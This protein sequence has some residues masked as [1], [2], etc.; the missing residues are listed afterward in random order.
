M[1]TPD[2]GTQDDEADIRKTL[3][4]TGT[5]TGGDRAE[6]GWRPI[7]V[8]ELELRL[9]EALELMMR[10]PSRWILI[11]ETASEHYVQFLANEDGVLFAECVSNEFLKGEARLSEEA[12]EL[13]PVLGWQWPAPPNQPNWV[14]VEFD[15]EAA[16][17]VAVLALHTLRR[18]FGCG[19]DE[20]LSA[21]IFR[22]G[23]PG[24]G[25]SGSETL[26]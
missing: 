22:S 24:D 25:G 11:V 26:D 19:D 23:Q 3:F 9:Q 16:L 13:L 21:R 4:G 1:S 14:T 5:G 18:V 6:H 17:D 15:E 10:S 12:E 20:V 7:T 8:R 2:A